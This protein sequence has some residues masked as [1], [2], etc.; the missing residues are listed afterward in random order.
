MVRYL[1][2]NVINQS[3]SWDKDTTV[4]CI[5]NIA[6]STDP[7]KLAPAVHAHTDCVV[8]LL[9]IQSSHYPTQTEYHD[10]VACNFGLRR[11]GKTYSI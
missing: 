9:Q 11:G 5:A 7:R 10:T 4:D 2:P 1:C 3:T 8:S 6:K